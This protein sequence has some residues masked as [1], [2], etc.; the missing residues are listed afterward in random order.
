MF[1]RVKLY[2]LYRVNF[3]GVTTKSCEGDTILGIPSGWCWLVGVQFGVV[4]NT[5]MFG[6]E[7]TQAGVMPGFE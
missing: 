3:V 2:E 5:E 6:V 1:Y 4:I 7:T